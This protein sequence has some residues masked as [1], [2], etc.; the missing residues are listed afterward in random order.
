MDWNRRLPHRAVLALILV[1]GFCVRA[2]TFQ[3]PILDHQ[4]WRQADTAAISRAFAEERYNILYPQ[5][6]WRGAAATGYVETGL[7]LHA[8]LVATI[9]RFSRFK[10][11]T[12]RLLSAVFFL[13]SCSLVW[14]FTRRRYGDATGLFA[15]YLY[16]FGFP[17]M[18]FMERAFMN[19]ALLVCLSLTSL[20]A[21]Q[22]YLEATDTGAAGV[23]RRRWSALVI[24]IGATAL[25]GAVKVPYLIVLAPI[26]GLFIERHGARALVRP[27]LWAVSLCAIGAAALWYQ[28][29]HALGVESGLTFGLA[30]KV[31]SVDLL[32]SERFYRMVSQRILR[33]ILGPLGAIGI[34]AG[35]IIAF[36]YRRWA[37]C[38]GLAGFAFY[39]MLVGGGNLAHNYYQ[40][41]MMPIAPTVVAAGLLGAIERIGPLR[42]AAPIAITTVLVLIPLITTVRS[43]SFHSWYE[44]PERDVHICATLPDHFTSPTERMVQIGSGDPRFLFC[45]DRKGWLLNPDD[46]ARVRAAWE[47]GARIA[48][49]HPETSEGVLTFLRE[50]GDAVPL[51]GELRAFRLREPPRLP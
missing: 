3:S 21:A 40:L 19:E 22:R 26:T 25:I 34:A 39:V 2:A 13:V 5:V 20:V 1:F 18:L 17:L 7:E 6:D 47:Q 9:A 44:I 35:A 12:G 10:A 49:V 4:G 29:A 38:L 30:D 46:E 27:E 15:A 31:S 28:H 41:A 36:R 32:L 43:A 42:R 48:L 33:D 50:H 8:F 51:P 45:L 23:T 14:A 37:E 16:A 11:E 24:V